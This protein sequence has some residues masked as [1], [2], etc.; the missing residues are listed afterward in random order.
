[1]A[2][3][4]KS[5]GAAVRAA[6][7]AAVPAERCVTGLAVLREGSEIVLFVYAVRRGAGYGRCR[8]LER[9]RASAS[10]AESRSARRSSYGRLRVPLRH[11]FTVTS[12]R[13]VLLLAAGM[14]SQGA[15]CLSQAE[16]SYRRW[17]RPAMGH[18]GD[19]SQTRVSVGQLLHVLIGYVWRG[20][21]A[22]SWCTMSPRSAVIGG[23]MVGLGR[24][25]IL[26]PGRRLSAP[27][28]SGGGGGI[29]TRRL[30]A[31]ANSHSSAAGR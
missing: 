1:M 22:F 6:R 7:A 3:E 24:R 18:L 15:A 10:W 30:P 21:R 5:I 29:F 23:L 11:L 31:A 26:A 13:C 14:A 12:G 19:R 20:P 16:I 28:P 17:A 9:R 4:A 27:P 25:R 8:H 2:D